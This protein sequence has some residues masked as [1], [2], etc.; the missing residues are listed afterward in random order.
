MKLKRNRISAV[1]KRPRDRK[2]IL[3]VV[4]IFAVLVLS[5][6]LTAAY[7]HHLKSRAQS[8]EDEPAVIPSTE[9]HAQIGAAPEIT[10]MPVSYEAYKDAKTL[11]GTV[12]ALSSDSAVTLVLYNE[13]GARFKSGASEL[14]GGAEGLS[15]LTAEEI[16]GA[17]R[18]AEIYTS[19]IFESRALSGEYESTDTALLS[20]YEQSL[21]IEICS[22]G[23]DEIILTGADL[24]NGG[25]QIAAEL[26]AQIKP[27]CKNTR[28]GA[29]V[30]A[31]NTNIDSTAEILAGGFDF[32]CLDLSAALLADTNNTFNPLSEDNA[33]N[34][35][36]GE[37]AAE[38]FEN[39]RAA[40][41]YELLHI[42]RYKMRVTLT[43]PENTSAER[44]RT[45]LL[46]FLADCYVNS[47]SLVSEQ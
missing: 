18:S 31:D 30:T 40:A 34:T 23:A 33:I 25:A 24:E 3:N 46:P 4:I 26:A 14:L 2:L 20:A 7:G 17:F 11:Q 36:N 13:S 8:F 9:T 43:L 37:N 19:V 16:I 41:E 39:L 44:C 35:E 6:V 12:S 22:A 28:L 21:I 45:V 27:L 1:Y 29:S 42:S 15:S 32:I 47:V 38:P 10:A 5:V